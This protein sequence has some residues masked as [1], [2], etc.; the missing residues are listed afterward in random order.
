MICPKC[1][2]TM[3]PIKRKHVKAVTYKAGYKTIE[4]IR[5]TLYKCPKD[6]IFTKP[7]S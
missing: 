4:V 3:K 5:R 1:N 2:S 7:L 6:C